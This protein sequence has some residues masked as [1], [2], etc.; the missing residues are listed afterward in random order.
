[1]ALEQDHARPIEGPRSRTTRGR[2]RSGGNSERMT[3]S[4]L[5]RL[6]GRKSCTGGRSAAAEKETIVN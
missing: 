6:S 5:K 4:Q 2:R 3:N 1:M